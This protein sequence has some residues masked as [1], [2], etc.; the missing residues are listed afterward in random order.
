MTER[1]TS[2][3]SD[4]ERLFSAL[5]K[6]P[7]PIYLCEQVVG[8]IRQERSRVTRVRLVVASLCGTLSAAVGVYAGI[9]LVS[10]ATSSGFFSYLALAFSDQGAVLKDAGSFGLS[11]LEAFPALETIAFLALLAIL[12]GSLRTFG[13]AL[14]FTSSYTSGALAAA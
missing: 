8:R 1:I 13:Q 9:V 4:Y 11:L 6:E 2:V 7:V 12:I 14:R 10:A 3:G 5:P